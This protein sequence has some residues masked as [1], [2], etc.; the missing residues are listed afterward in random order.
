MDHSIMEKIEYSSTLL[1]CN[2]TT[3]FYFQ[4]VH[5]DIPRCSSDS[6][7]KVNKKSTKESIQPPCFSY[8]LKFHLVRNQS[9]MMTTKTKQ[10][11]C[12]L[13]LFYFE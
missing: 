3:T 4:C 5:V 10:I 12:D 13:C 7:V 1:N 9:N 2:Q 11:K 6:M 8:R